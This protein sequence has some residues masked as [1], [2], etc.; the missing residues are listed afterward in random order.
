MRADLKKK[1][2]II[3]ECQDGTGRLTVEGKEI[4]YKRI[5]MDER[6]EIFE[7]INQPMM[8]DAHRLTR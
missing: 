7:F 2:R 8:R 1:I 5:L 3:L 6:V 4:I